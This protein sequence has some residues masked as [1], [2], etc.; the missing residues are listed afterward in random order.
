MKWKLKLIRIIKRY[1]MLCRD[2]KIQLGLKQWEL[3]WK[4]ICETRFHSD[5][6]YIEWCS[7][8]KRSSYYLC[9]QVYCFRVPQGSRQWVERSMRMKKQRNKAALRPMSRRD[10]WV[11]LLAHKI[12]WKQI[13]YKTTV[14]KRIALSEKS[15]CWPP[16]HKSKNITK[17][18]NHL[19]I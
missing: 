4:Y 7:L 10:F 3:R 16:K 14:F 6:S 5:F 17:T 13:D 1:G 8:F 18:K 9:T 11:R 15:W 19:V 12:D 2:G